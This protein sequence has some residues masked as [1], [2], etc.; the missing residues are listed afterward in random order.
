MLQSDSVLKNFENFALLTDHTSISKLGFANHTY[1]VLKGRSGRYYAGSPANYSENAKNKEL[2]LDV[3]AENSLGD[4]FNSIKEKVGGT[5]RISNEEN[6][7]NMSKNITVEQL[8]C[9][10]MDC[11]RLHCLELIMF[12]NYNKYNTYCTLPYHLP[13]DNRLLEI[14]N[15]IE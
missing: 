13:R 7:L 9:E 11:I 8:Q 4:L 5:W 1:F 15:I 2:F 6:I 12:D 14:L 10:G 3:I